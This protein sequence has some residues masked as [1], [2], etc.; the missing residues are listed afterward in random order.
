M[1]TGMRNDQVRF[2][3]DPFI[4]EEDVE[5]DHPRTPTRRRGETAEF[6]LDLLELGQQRTGR[7]RRI[8]LRDRIQVRALWG[9]ADRFGLDDRRHLDDPHPWRRPQPF[10]GAGDVRLSISFV[11]A[12]PDK[13]LSHYD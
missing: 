7:L 13:G 5:I 10:D 2:L 1:H 11:G 12:Y 6:P 4:V 3:N 9:A 8:E